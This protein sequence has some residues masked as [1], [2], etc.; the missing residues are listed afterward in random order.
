[1]RIGKRTAAIT[2]L[3]AVGAVLLCPSFATA[4]TYT[5]C[6]SV[7]TASRICGPN[8][9]F[10]AIWDKPKYGR[11]EYRLCVALPGGGK[12]CDRYDAGRRGYD[13][14]NFY[15]RGYEM[16]TYVVSWR[17]GGHLIDRDSLRITAGESVRSP[18]SPGS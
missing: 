14:V 17:R 3:G 12:D 16:G 1:M 10:G 9:L 5:Y 11:T 4:K 7:D 6:G 13:A 8:N 2:V 18:V 15:G